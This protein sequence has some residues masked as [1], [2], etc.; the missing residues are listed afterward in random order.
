MF[1]TKGFVKKSCSYP[2]SDLCIVPNLIPI[3]MS[4]YQISYILYTFYILGL[5][6]NNVVLKDAFTFYVYSKVSRYLTSTGRPIHYR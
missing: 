2:T 4:Y 1:G 6:W 3:F 5:S